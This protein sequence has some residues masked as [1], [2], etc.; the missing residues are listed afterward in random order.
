MNLNN[1]IKL[2]YSNCFDNSNLDIDTDYLD[3]VLVVLTFG[4]IYRLEVDILVCRLS[5]IFHLELGLC[6]LFRNIISNMRFRLLFFV[7]NLLNSLIYLYSDNLRSGL[8]YD[9]DCIYRRCLHL[10]LMRSWVTLI[11]I[12]HYLEDK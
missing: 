11:G 5:M 2:Y 4:N 7:V 9:L 8:E 6:S 10:L 12:F 3:M 1:L